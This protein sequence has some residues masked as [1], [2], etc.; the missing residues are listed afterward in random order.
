MTGCGA[1]TSADAPQPAA[2]TGEYPNLFADGGYQ[3][4]EIRAKVDAA[5]RQLFHGDPETQAVYFP[6]GENGNGPLAYIKDVASND[7]RSEG[8]S[9]GMMI[10]V[11]LDQRAEFDALWNYALSFMEESDPAHPA[12]GY[13]AWSVRPDGTPNDD[14]PAPDGEEYFATALYFASARWGDGDGLRNYKAHAD[15][16]VHLMRHRALISG[17]AKNGE[18]TAGALFDPDQAIVRFTPVGVRS[19]QTD[20]SYHLPAFYEIWAMRGPEEDREFWKRAATASRAF[21]HKT[22]HPETGLSPDY[23]HF[24]GRPYKTEWNPNSAYFA[25][26]SWRTAMNWSVDWSWWAVDPAQQEL[27]DRIQAFFESEGIDHYA[28]VYTLDGDVVMRGHTP[29]LVSMNAVASLAATHPRSKLFVQE[30]WELDI[31]SGPYRYY[32]GML[33]MMALLHASGEFRVW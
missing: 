1:S 5:F 6:A 14:M 4:A 27:S 20:P 23:A 24:D 26:D 10:A 16:L 22:T 29:G 3:Q 7:V 12:Y 28:M 13:F 2:L 11:Q 9:Y 21:F 33:Y 32:D 31:P 17:Q 18:L 15:R 25:F 19:D 8:M 30:L